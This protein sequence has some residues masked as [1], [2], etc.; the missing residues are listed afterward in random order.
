MRRS[1]R[2]SITYERNKVAVNI[3]FYYD[4]FDGYEYC[5][6][7]NVV[8]EDR[9][10]LELVGRIGA[11]GVIRHLGKLGATPTWRV[12][13]NPPYGYHCHVGLFDAVLG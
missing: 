1:S 4:G 11:E 10:D 6:P 8:G 5:L 3:E 7:K 2:E 13:G 9:A 12:K